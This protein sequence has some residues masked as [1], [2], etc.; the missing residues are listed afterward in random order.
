QRVAIARALVNRPVILLA[1]EPTG[2]LDSKVTGEV[3]ALLQQ[4]NDEG[5]TIILVTHEPDVAQYAKRKIVVRDGLIVEDAAIKDRTIAGAGGEGPE[6][7]KSKGLAH[8]EAAAPVGSALVK[9]VAAPSPAPSPEQ[10]GDKGV[11][12]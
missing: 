3:M 2:N 4:L 10:S 6:P 7:K 8:G 11:A 1:D 9:L 5:I 12:S